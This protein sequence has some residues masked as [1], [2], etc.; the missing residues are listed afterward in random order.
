VREAVEVARFVEELPQD[1]RP[2][3]PLAELVVGTCLAAFN[4][5]LTVDHTP[6]H[7]QMVRDLLLD[8]VLRMMGRRAAG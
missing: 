8:A 4:N 5:E 6:E 7:R 2:A 3:R 1:G